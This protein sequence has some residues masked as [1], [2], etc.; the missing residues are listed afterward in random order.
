VDFSTN[1]SLREN[2]FLIQANDKTIN[3]KNISATDYE[4]EIYV[5]YKQKDDDGNYF[6]GITF[7][8]K[9]NGLGVDEIQ[10]LPASHFVVGG[11]EVVFVDYAG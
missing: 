6:G 5:Y 9:A 7:R 10:Q 8:T 1:V 11:S 2:Q 3:I 4:S